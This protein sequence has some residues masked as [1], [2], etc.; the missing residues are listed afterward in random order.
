VGTLA[1][2]GVVNAC[3]LVGSLDAL[4]GSI[5]GRILLLKLVF[6]LM[7]IGIGA[8]NLLILKPR[9]RRV[10]DARDVL[11]SL[12]RNVLLEACGG[13]AVLVVVGVLG[14]TAPPGPL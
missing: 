10:E 11:T 1:A 4:F 3:F 2:T 8:W 14:I 12:R 5:Y 7:M 6:V 9:L 13:A